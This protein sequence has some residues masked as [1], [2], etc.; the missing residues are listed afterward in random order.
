MIHKL[1]RKTLIP[2]QLIA[3]CITLFIGVTIILLSIAIY[4]DTS[5]ILESQ[6]NIFKENTAI[7]NKKVT[8]FKS[9]NKKGLY[10]TKE[11]KEELIAKDYIKDASP[12][13]SASF[14][15]KAFTPQMDNMPL[16]QTDLFFESI[17]DQYI[18]QKTEDWKWQEEGDFIPVIIPE[19][20]IKLYNFGFAESQGLP[21]VSKNVIS[22]ITFTIEISDGYRSKKFNSRIVGFSTK[23]NSIL[24]PQDFMLWANKNYGRTSKNPNATRLL[25]EFTDMSDENMLAF[26][27]EKNYAINQDKLEFGKL[28]FFFKSAFA[29]MLAIALIIVF[30]S[31]A[32]IIL[33]INVIL[34]KNKDMIINLY[35]IGYAP[36]KIALFYKKTI[37]IATVVSFML[38]IISVVLLRSYYLN[39]IQSLFEVSSISYFFIGVMALSLLILLLLS[40]WVLV[41]KKITAIA[42]LKD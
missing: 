34:Q 20:Y 10:F 13:V 8:V 36:K 38:S 35:N 39:K 3:Y 42:L 15:I 5:P 19:N 7:I 30:L 11:E 26:F 31:I 40:Y 18:D 29:F 41:Q 14:K 2:S 12:F 32:F 4:Q 1:Q 22:N 17:P 37:G 33:S 23:I 25:I 9:I 16:F 24:V 28:L 6:S 27:K 21:V